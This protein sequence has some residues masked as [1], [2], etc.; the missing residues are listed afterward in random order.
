M[1]K[2]H[3]QLLGHF[4]L[5]TS[6]GLNIEIT[7][8]KAKALLAY[9]AISSQP[10]SRASLAELLWERHDRVQAMTNLRQALSVIQRLFPP[11]TGWLDCS[12]LTNN[13]TKRCLF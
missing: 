6:A 11:A 8:K 12:Y 7:S 1:K 10:V 5:K 3:L 9:L 13:A 2:L 4:S